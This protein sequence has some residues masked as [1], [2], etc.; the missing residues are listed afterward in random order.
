MKENKGKMKMEFEYKI[1]DIQRSEDGWYIIPKELME[2]PYFTDTDGTI[3][4]KD[5]AYVLNSLH[6]LD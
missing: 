4:C 6:F 3:Y 1:E 2:Y 5:E